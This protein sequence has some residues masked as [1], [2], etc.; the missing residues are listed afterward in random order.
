[1]SRRKLPNALKLEVLEEKGNIC[2]Y[3]GGEA[4]ALDHVL[5]YSRDPLHMKGNLVPSCNLCNSLASDKVFPS[6]DAK[7]RHILM[8]RL[9]RAD[10]LPPRRNFNLLRRSGTPIPRPC[11][12]V[13][14]A[15]TGAA[16]DPRLLALR[17]ELRRKLALSTYRS[18]AAEYGVNPGTVWK[19]VNR[20]Y[21]PPHP[22]S[23]LALGLSE[24]MPW[25]A[26]RGAD[27][28][29]VAHHPVVLRSERACACGCGSYLVPGSWNQAYLP[30]HRKHRRSLCPK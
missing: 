13:F 17:A 30:G 28:V 3:C 15:E 16:V 14:L 22:A 21:D 10:G 8:R 6:F 29:S 5:P 12:L 23:R 19:I 24:A 9:E 27:G 25:L 7:R 11:A 4:A 2:V 20:N 26:V 18:V 1:M